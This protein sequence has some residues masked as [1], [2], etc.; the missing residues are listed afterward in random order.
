MAQPYS[1]GPVNVYIAT[2]T[3]TSGSA[4]TVG[5][6]DYLGTGETGPD[7][8]FQPYFHDLINDLTG[9]KSPLDRL[10]QGSDAVSTLKLNRWNKTCLD[11]VFPIKPDTPGTLDLLSNIGSLLIAGGKTFTVIYSFPGATR[12][13]AGYRFFFSYAEKITRSTGTRVNSVTLSFWHGRGYVNSGGSNCG[14]LLYDTNVTGNLCP[15]N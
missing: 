5:T 10:Y 11:K 12:D 13:V 8:S 4:P 15:P 2:T 7:I 14:M 3:Y 1:S 6:P 9:T